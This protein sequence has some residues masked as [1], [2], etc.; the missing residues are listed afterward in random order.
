[1]SRRAR[2]LPNRSYRWS[3]LDPER[4]N[5]LLLLGGIG[6]VVLFAILLIGYGYYT[7]RLAPGSDTVVR[8]GDRNFDYDYFERRMK[9][10]LA[11]GR[12]N[13]ANVGDGVTAILTL[14]QREELLRQGAA[15]I[16]VEVSEEEIEAR[17]RA[18][19]GISAN[20]TREQFAAQLRQELVRLQLSLGDFRELAIAEV[21]ETKLREHF[22]AAVPTEAEH[23]SLLLIQTGTESA[24]IQARDKLNAGESFATV[25]ASDS[26]HASRTKDGVVEFV[27]TE[28]L[29]KKVGETA[30][31]ISPGTRSEIIDDPQGFYIIEVTG[32][33][34][35]PVTEDGRE[36]LG[37][38]RLNNLLAETQERLGSEITITPAQLQRLARSLAPG[39]G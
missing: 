4:R 18:R 11:R 5:S 22:E 23:V 38:Q 8:V 15:S 14:I 12:I 37:S 24:A 13:A 10:E 1:L 17:Y 27:P 34:T 9:S 25:A 21:L 28:S 19:V 29:P 2:A 32:R 36:L 16:G 26:I 33:E 7:E 35:Q 30:A 31:S 39:V 20:A 3:D 6:L